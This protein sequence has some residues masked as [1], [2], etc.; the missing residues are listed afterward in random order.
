MKKN[1]RGFPVRIA[2]LC[3]VFMLA[4]C[5]QNYQRFQRAE[6]F[7]NYLPNNF[8]RKGTIH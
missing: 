2:S 7:G 5:C 4:G 1:A 3:V 8:R 6:D